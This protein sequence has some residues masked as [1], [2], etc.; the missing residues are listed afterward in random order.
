MAHEI[1]TTDHVVL[2][3]QPAWHGLGT[4]VAN[5]PTPG[6]A[7]KLAKLDWT[8]EQW[9]LSATDG[10]TRLCVE[11]KV[12]N[13]RKDTNEILG[14]VGSEWQPFQNIDVATF[15]ESLAEMN[16]T[17]KVESAGS[18]RGGAKIWF[19]LRGESFS[20]RSEDE[21]RPYIL[22]SNGFDGMTGFRCTPTTNRV[23]CS[24]TLHMVIPKRE[25]DG[26]LRTISDQA[27]V[28]SHTSTL[29]K[30]L[31]QAKAALGLYGHSLSEHRA[32]IDTL[33]AR[34]VTSEMC[35]RFFL[36]CYARDFE[37]IPDT[38]VTSAQKAARTKALDGFKAFDKRFQK[39]LDLAGP[40]AWNALNAYTGWLQNDKPQRGK[41]AAKNLEAK[42]HSN[43]FGKNAD[44]AIGAMKMALSL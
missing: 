2:T 5:A 25:R 31:A 13:V 44:L 6:D 32:L 17:V 27:F 30:R 33:A 38:P 20:V 36:E 42:Q 35:K 1:T 23:V 22:V 28:C 39:E 24:N 40:T 10:S 7:L 16:D 43:L 15:C 3:E 34:D 18:I 21:V 4:V 41:N 8:V 29:E 9:P 12:A 19:L 37:A 26:S 14:I 11:N